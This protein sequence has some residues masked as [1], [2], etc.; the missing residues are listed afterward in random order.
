MTNESTET[1]PVVRER[2]W[3]QLENANPALG[4]LAERKYGRVFF[5]LADRGIIL[6]TVLPGR[7]NQV[8]KKDRDG[9]CVE[10]LLERNDEATDK[11][12]FDY[13]EKDSPTIERELGFKLK[14]GIDE[15]TKRYRITYHNQFNPRCEE[16]WEEHNKWFIETRA[17][18]ERVFIPRLE[19]MKISR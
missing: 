1:A 12:I 10:I 9:G 8:R 7:A 5:D 15:K 17:A 6:A 16:E 11:A 13:L 3:E 2:F 4:K 18:F 19:K 14:W